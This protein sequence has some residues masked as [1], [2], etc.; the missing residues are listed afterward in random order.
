MP[1]TYEQVL[2]NLAKVKVATAHWKLTL[3]GQSNEWEGTC[4]K[5]STTVPAI[6]LKL[7]I[8]PFGRGEAWVCTDCLNR[9]KD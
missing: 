5:C 7:T 8:L 4:Q 6:N 2:D 1:V 9:P 3:N